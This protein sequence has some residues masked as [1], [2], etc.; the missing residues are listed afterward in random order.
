[1]EQRALFS[2]SGPVR[3]EEMTTLSGD[4]ATKV[5]EGPYSHAKKWHEDLQQIARD[6]GSEPGEVCFFY[7]TCP[8][9][10]KA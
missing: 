5:F 9:Y 3:G 6:R 7:T 4:F 1:M 10:A 8:K 2:V